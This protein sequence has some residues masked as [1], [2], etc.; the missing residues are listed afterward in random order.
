MVV[1]ARPPLG[2]LD[3]ADAACLSPDEVLSRL[4]SGPDG[5]SSDD[6]AERLRQMGFPVGY[7]GP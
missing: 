3:L 7:G 6:A 1:V 5:L 2:E 4:E